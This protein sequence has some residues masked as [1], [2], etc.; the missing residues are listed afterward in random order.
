MEGVTA[1]SW[2]PV[3]ESSA[4]IL[5]RMGFKPVACR[6]GESEAKGK[7]SSKSKYVSNAARAEG[8]AIAMRIKTPMVAHRED[9][10]VRIIMVFILWWVFFERGKNPPIA[11][12]R[13][14]GH[15][16]DRPG[17]PLTIFTPTPNSRFKFHKRSYLFI[18]TNNETLSVIVVCVSNPDCSA[19]AIQS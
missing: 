13:N 1:F 3:P 17:L 11:S 14:I 8:A 5:P 4:E 10:S 12:R 15:R 9:F 7:L 19:L 2:M 18:R 6:P 16:P